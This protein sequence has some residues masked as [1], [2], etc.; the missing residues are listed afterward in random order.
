MPVAV[1]PDS[2][3][4]WLD[5]AADPDEVRSLL[6]PP[7]ETALRA[8]PVSTRVNDVRNNDSSLLDDA[9][10]PLQLF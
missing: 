8:R 1:A 9:Q 7:P 4:V 5:P 3:D 10:P 2:W 6:V